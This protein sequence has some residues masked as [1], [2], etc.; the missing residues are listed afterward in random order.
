MNVRCL[1]EGDSSSVLTVQAACYR[2]ELIESDEAFL[3]K[4][5]LFPEGCLGAFQAAKMQGYVFGHPWT[6]GQIV[7]LGSSDYSL[8]RDAGCMYL[9]DLAVLP[10]LRRT[11]VAVLLVRGLVEVGVR[12]GVDAFALVA[13]QDSEAY[14]VLWGFKVESVF[15]YGAG[16]RA[17]Y[18]TCEGVPTWR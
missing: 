12:N 1:T 17:S 14:W 9:H 13:V 4:M 2:P 7:P 15:E 16:V 8:P 3:R 6:R 18:M 5:A 10:A 11:G